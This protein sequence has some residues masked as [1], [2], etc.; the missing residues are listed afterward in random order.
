[1]KRYGD[2]L[3]CKEIDSTLF[4]L[5]KTQ[6]KQTSK[7]N[8][9]NKM[10]QLEACTFDEIWTTLCQSADF[11]NTNMDGIF[12]NDRKSQIDFALG[13]KF[14]GI[15]YE[16]PHLN[17]YNPLTLYMKNDPKYFE[18]IF[19]C[20]ANYLPLYYDD[21]RMSLIYNFSCDARKKK[22]D[23]PKY[24]S[25]FEQIEESEFEYNLPF[26]YTE[27]N[28]VDFCSFTWKSL[29]HNSEC[30]ECFKQP[31]RQREKYI[32]SKT[33]FKI[34]ETFSRYPSILITDNDRW[35]IE[36]IFGMNTI[37]T[38]MQIVNTYNN[39]YTHKNIYIPILKELLK[40]KPI[41]IRLHLTKLVCSLL[42][43]IQELTNEY[44]ETHFPTKPSSIFNET[45]VASLKKE[46]A[47]SISKINI[48]YST[49][50]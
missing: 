39:S 48:I 33:L 19:M 6:I 31:E 46:L 36:K 32:N 20:L 2:L 40:C 22:K 45:A 50:L 7:E 5:I 47:E 18:K 25:T 41:H 49:F 30:L 42:L 9:N 28:Y 13:Y 15:D 1:M 29:Y 17:Y 24:N 16:H 44:D 26:I 12:Y 35:I 37:L 4:D 21:T 34:T 27:N 11:E 43:S 10:T 23:R 14:L 3:N 8:N 38:L